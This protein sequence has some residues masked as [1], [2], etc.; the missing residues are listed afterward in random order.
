M[1]NYI[2]NSG[3]IFIYALVAFMY[4]WVAKKFADWRTTDID[5][6]Y[7]IEEKSNLAIGCR[8]VGLYAGIALGMAGALGGASKGFGADIVALLWEGAIV[9][10]CMFIARL[11]ND[12]LTLHRIENDKEAKAGNTAVGLVEMGNYVGTGL[13]LWGAFGG[14]GGGLVSA[15]VFF[16]LGQ[17]TLLALFMLYELITPFSVRAEVAKGNSAAGLAAAGMMISLGI[18]LRASI[19]GP[20]VG[21]TAD[22]GSFAGSAVV[23]IAL[24]LIF[25]KGIDWLFLPNTDLKTEVATDQNVSAVAVT[26]GIM[27]GLA[28]IISAAL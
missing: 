19:A 14:E 22:L 24:L 20:T 5:D 8:R 16:G 21:W 9:V 28:L 25:R 23:G 7:E 2:I 17:V 6:D 12:N 13:I 27:F 1:E 26:Y 18:I 3:Y 11:V 10:A 4:M 15:M